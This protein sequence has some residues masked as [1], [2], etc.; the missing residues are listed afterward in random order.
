MLPVFGLLGFNLP[1]LHP[2]ARL[3]LAYMPKYRLNSG[4]ANFEAKRVGSANFLYYQYEICRAILVQNLVNEV[5][6]TIRS[7][8]TH[9]CHPSCLY[10]SDVYLHYKTVIELYM[11]L[12]SLLLPL[13]FSILIYLIR[14]VDYVRKDHVRKD[15]R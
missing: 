8:P 2:E 4:K 6:N 15:Q 11:S 9:V 10:T 12:F 5:P 7:K 14:W 3:C 1:R 13:P